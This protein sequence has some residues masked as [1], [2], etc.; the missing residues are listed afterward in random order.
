MAP[1][2]KDGQVI[3]FEPGYLSTAYLLKYCDKEIISIEAESSPIDCRIISPCVCKVLFKNVMNPMGVYP[4]CKRDV[5]EKMLDQLG[6]PYRFT[7][8][9]I[10]AALHN[11]NLIVHT[12]GAI[13]SIPRIE[14]T[15]GKYWMYKEVF[16]PHVWNVCESLDAEKMEVMRKTGVKKRQSYVEACQERNF[17]NDTRTPLDS[18]FD[19]AMNSSP[20][21]P[22]V[23]DSRYITEDV[24]QGLVLLESLGRSL[25]VPTPTC[26]ALIDIASASLKTNF[27]EIG[28]TIDRLGK[29]SL[30]KIQED[31]K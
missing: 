24:P 12:V 25:N 21:G 19:Y 8:N 17:I 1:Y 16:T 11:P 3:L 5:A 14:Y 26:S 29:D 22:A 4:A 30:L 23:P 7:E 6:F 10:E 31:T 9:V 20:E 15:N 18:F 2:L 13:F 27:R 28:R